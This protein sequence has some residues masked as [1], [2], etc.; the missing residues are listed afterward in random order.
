MRVG[1]PHRGQRLVP[2][3]A[4]NV[5]AGHV[6]RETARPSLDA[7]RAAPDTV[8]AMIRSP[9]TR[10]LACYYLVSTLERRQGR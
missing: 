2:L 5:T 8:P 7:V 1:L 10:H 3:P 6:W 9:S 4:P